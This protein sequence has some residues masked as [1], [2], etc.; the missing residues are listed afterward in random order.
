MS[1]MSDM[2]KLVNA[3]E[4]AKKARVGM[5]LTYFDVIELLGELNSLYE[6]ID[7]LEAERRWVPV[8]ERLPKESGWYRVGAINVFY[9]GYT[10]EVYFEAN[11]TKSGWQSSVRD[12]IYCW[13]DGVPELPKPP[14]VQESE[15]T[16]CEFCG[17]NKSDIL[18]N[19]I[20]C[21]S[22]G[23]KI[24]NIAPPEVQE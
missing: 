4:L 16:S 8:S 15:A 13:L 7:V 5:S 10:D 3:M 21:T 12:E 11:N 24:G 2:F 18:M 9:E 19:S 23:R 1:E 14:E 6:Y 22:C 20:V 17:S